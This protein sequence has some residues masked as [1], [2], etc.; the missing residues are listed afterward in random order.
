MDRLR[1]ALDLGDDEAQAWRAT[2]P[3]LLPAAARGAWSHAARLL[4]DLQKVCTDLERELFAVDLVEWACSLGQKPIKRPLPL[5]AEALVVQ[6]LRSAAA[7]L[8]RIHLQPDRRRRLSDLLREALHHREEHLRRRI[9]PLLA[10]SLDEVGFVP[11]NQAESI[12]RSKLIEELLD[13]I[14]ERGF[15]NMGDLR[16]AISRNQLKLGDSDPIRILRGDLLLKA[17][18]KLAITLDGVYH[19]GEV[20]LRWLQRFSGLF[21]ANFIGRWLTLFVILPFGGAFA[22]LIFAQ[23]VLHLATVHVHMP[24]PWLKPHEHH[25]DSETTHSGSIH[26][27]MSGYELLA[28][29]IG[30]G[31]FFL[32]LLHMPAFR[33]SV[34]TG[35]KQTGRLLR[36]VFWDL[37]AAFV[38]WAPVRAFLDSAPVAFF[39]RRVMRPVL[40]G[41]VAVLAWFPFS[42]PGGWDDLAIGVGAFALAFLF[43]NSRVGQRTEEAVSDW[44]GAN[45]YWLRDDVLPGLLRLILQ[46]FRDLLDYLERLFYTVDEWFRFRPGDSRLALFYK[47]VLGLFW[48]LVTYVFR[49]LINLMI[50]PTVNPIKHFPAVTVGAKLII[51]MIP[52][53]HGLMTAAMAPVLGVAAAQA[54]S[55]FMIVMIPGIFGFAVWEFKENWKLYRAN[56]PRGLRPVMIGH[57]GETMLRLMKPGFHSGTLPKAFARLRAALRQGDARKIHKQKETLHH[58]DEAV[59]HFAERELIRLLQE[60]RS[61][62]GLD[63]EVRDVRLASNRVEIA[64]A[65]SSLGADALEI[66]FEERCGWL[67][68]GIRSAGWLSRIDATQRRAFRVALGGFYQLAGAYLVR[69]ELEAELP[70]PYVIEDEGVVFYPGG[71]FANEEKRPL[72]CGVTC[73]RLL[74]SSH[75]IPWTEWVTAWERDRAGQGVDL[76]AIGGCRVLPA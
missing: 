58:I 66:A 22:T 60:S 18:R 24:W 9:R 31:V 39:R 57:H 47:P 61:W 25:G 13:R 5:Q 8:G 56:R 38:Y 67:V 64:L 10:S 17:N 28:W 76:A 2:L 30:L 52:E 40:I 23:E 21:F 16:D 74:F 29:L 59:R 68:A 19:R 41:F 15:F 1:R 12:A 71:D 36:A 53:W 63:L 42:P 73:D 7:R 43:F 55:G 37:P 46:V 75:A 51:P 65:C 32:L 27:E 48:F 20:Y 72:V 6:H 3:A 45:W 62:G 14:I 69:E 49:I 4:Y 11:T 26:L 35:L 54:I 34:W 33:G 50:E 70:G 44:L